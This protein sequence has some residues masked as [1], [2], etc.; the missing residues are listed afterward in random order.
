MSLNSRYERRRRRHDR[1]RR[2]VSGTALRPRM[3]IMASN[4]C[5]YVQLIDDS[6]GVTLA[7]AS[8]GGRQK[9]E[10]LNVETAGRAG[11]SVAEQAMQLGISEVVVDRG[12]FRYHGRVKALVEGAL[13]AGLKIGKS[14]VTELLPE[15]K[16]AQ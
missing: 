1:V 11:T 14:I 4:C 13:R 8:A 10:R 3:A 5:I 7:A 16:E 6:K 9:G 12:G 15:G 2:K